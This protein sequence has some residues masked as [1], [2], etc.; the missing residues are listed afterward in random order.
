M[1]ARL[2]LLLPCARRNWLQGAA[3]GPRFWPRNGTRLVVPGMPAHADALTTERALV[4]EIFKSGNLVTCC[5]GHHSCRLRAPRLAV[6]RRSRCGIGDCGQAP[7]SSPRSRRGSH[8]RGSRHRSHHGHRNEALS[9]MELL[10]VETQTAR[11]NPAHT[12][13]HF[14]I[15]FR[16]L[17]FPSTHELR[18]RTYS[19]FPSIGPDGPFRCCGGQFVIPATQGNIPAPHD[20]KH[21]IMWLTDIAGRC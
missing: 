2:V 14:L 3:R 1:P 5:D 20:P 19:H 12:T 13:D 15:T 11:M 6:W 7:T 18:R 8:G 17:S 21:R 10:A 16:R 4:H 9:P